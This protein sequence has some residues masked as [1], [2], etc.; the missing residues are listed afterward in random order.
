M[1]IPW[2]PAA[3]ENVDRQA[4]Y[5]VRVDAPDWSFQDRTEIW[6]GALLYARLH[7]GYVAGRPIFMAKIDEPEEAP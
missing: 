6:S 7:P 5:I 4:H 3:P 2:Q 1:T